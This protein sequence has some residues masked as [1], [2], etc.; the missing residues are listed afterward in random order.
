MKREVLAAGRPPGAAP[1]A[2]GGRRPH[3]IPPTRIQK[4]FAS[5]RYYSTPVNYLWLYA[6]PSC[7]ADSVGYMRRGG[8]LLGADAAVFSLWDAGTARECRLARYGFRGMCF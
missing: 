1:P 8:N 2:E 3:K 6:L 5:N 7:Q 4:L